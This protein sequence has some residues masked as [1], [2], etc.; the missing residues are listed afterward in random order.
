MQFFTGIW[1]PVIRN[2]VMCQRDF[3][4]QNAV[5]HR[6]LESFNAK[7][8]NVSEEFTII[9]CSVSQEFRDL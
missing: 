2:T 6:N 3:V 9:E 1:R 5:S 8:G 7:Y 4:S